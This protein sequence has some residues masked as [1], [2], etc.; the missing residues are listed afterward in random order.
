MEPLEQLSARCTQA[1]AELEQI[2][3]LKDLEPWR[4]AWLGKKSELSQSRKQIGKLPPEERKNFGGVVNTLIERLETALAARREVLQARAQDELL[5]AR[6]VDVT[7][8]GKPAW[9]GSRHPVTLVTNQ[10]RRIFQR[11]GFQ[12][13][14]GPEMETDEYCFEMLNIPKDHPARDMW[15]TFWLKDG[16]CLRPHT[17]PLQIR[18]MLQARPA[19]LKIICPGRVFR[20]ENITARSECQFV[21]VEGLEV[22]RHVTMKDLVAVL[23]RFAREMFGPE[24]RIRLRNSFFPFT[25]PSLEVDVD[26][27]KCGGS[28]CNLCKHTGWIEILGAG[29]VNPRVLAGCGYDPDEFSGFAFGLGVERIALLKYAIDDIRHFY[30]NDL[31]FLQQFTAE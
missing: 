12:E 21:Q 27:F 10:I 22:G 20:Y 1:L 6:A 16:R 18:A 17:S 4:V 26:C 11:M 2:T 28:G 19:P 3:L 9:P 29:M 5:R 25:E 24:R 15:D 13:V 31:R 7:L 8:P 23:R 30:R 14:S